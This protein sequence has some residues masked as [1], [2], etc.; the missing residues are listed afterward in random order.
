[1]KRKKY[2]LNELKHTHTQK[3][4]Y[5]GGL[6]FPPPRNLPDSGIEPGSPTLQADSLL[7][8]L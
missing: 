2:N 3:K 4:E 8:V 1:M 6:Q 7:S 5:W